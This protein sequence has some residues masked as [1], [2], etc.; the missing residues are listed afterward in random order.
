MRSYQGF[1]G[2]ITLA[3]LC[4]PAEASPIDRLILSEV[5]YDRAGPD[6]GFEWVELFNGSSQ[7]IDLSGW[8]LGYGGSSYA[9]GTAQL[10]GSVG[11]AQYFLVGGPLS[12]ATNGQPTFDLTLNF[13]PDL[14]NSGTLAD[15]VALFNMMA[16]FI[17][18][19]TVPVD[20]VIYGVTNSSLLLDESGRPG[21]VLVGDAASGQSLTRI[22]ARNWRV[23]EIP[24]PGEGG[25]DAASVDEPTSAVL[26]LGA[27]GALVLARRR[28]DRAR[29]SSTI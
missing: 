11:A 23:S 12:D 7:A 2:L 28:R 15:G 29:I 6:S 1:L 17:L 5:F 9:A 27:L 19:A 18:P 8:S 10:E 3:G 24:S 22:D 25:L 26:F 20:A 4:A 16:A 13:A 21:A 14:Q